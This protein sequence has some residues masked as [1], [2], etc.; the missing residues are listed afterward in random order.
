M[1][2]VADVAAPRRFEE[3]GRIAPEHLTGRFEEDPRVRD[4]PRHRNP[5]IVDSVL[6]ADE[7]AR[8]QRTIGPRQHVVVQRVHLAEG[9]AH[10]ADLGQQAARQF[11]ERQKSFL[12]IDARFPERDEEIG[13][14]VRID[15]GLEGR[16]RF[17]HLERRLRVDQV[18]AGRAEEVAD[19]RHVRVEDLRSRDGA[20]VY[21]QRA[22]RATRAFRAGR[23]RRRRL[24]RLP[25]RLRSRAG[26]SGRRRGRRRRLSLRRRE[27]AFERRQPIAVLLFERLEVAAQLIDLLSQRL[28]V[29]LC[30]RRGRTERQRNGR[31]H[32]ARKSHGSHET[33]PPATRRSTAGKTRCLGARARRAAIDRWSGW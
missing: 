33:P 26:L 20:A 12:E 27:L 25:R 14:R 19:H 15:D 2:D 9:R 3:I 28:R 24:R 17:V 22:A 8:H 32:R 30:R 23:H 29:V 21:R 10:L 11:R 13:A 16:L 4:Q 31:D 1:A 6:A 5:R 7:I 18:P